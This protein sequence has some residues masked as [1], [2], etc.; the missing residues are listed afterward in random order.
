MA[1]ELADRRDRLFGREGDLAALMKRARYKGLTAVVARPQKGKSW[2]LTE[3]AR[4]LGAEPQPPYL[5]G[6]AESFGE[7]PDLLLRTVVDL[8]ARWL[9]DAGSLEKARKLWE[10]E[11]ANLLPGVAMAV[12]KIFKELADAVTKPAAVVVEE[13]FNGLIAA[14]ERPRTGGFKLPTLR[15]EQ[16]RDLVKSV[17]DI[18][19][20]P[21]ALF[22]DQWEK[23]PDAALE[24]KTLDSSL[25]HLDYWPRCHIFLALRPDRLAHGEV[26][27]LAD[28]MPGAAE[29]YPLH[30]MELSL[31]EGRRLTAFVRGTVSAAVDQSDEALLGMVDGYPGVIY[32]W[33]RDYQRAHMRTRDDLQ[34]VAADAQEYRFSDLKVLL[35]K[36]D[37][38]HRRLA[39]RLALLPVSAAPVWASI[40]GEVL[41]GL[42]AGLM[43]DLRLANLLESADPPSFGH[44]QRWEAAR[45]WVV[46]NL[47][48]NARSEAESLISSIAAPVRELSLAVLPNV[49]ILFGLLPTARQLKLDDLS[50]ALCQSAASLLLTAG[51]ADGA[52]IRRARQTSKLRTGTP[53]LAMGLL[54][55]LIDAKAEGHLTRR[56]AL[57]EELRALAGAQPEDTAIREPLAR[58]VLSALSP[59]KTEDDRKRRDALLEELRALA[60]AHPKDAAV[61]EWL[62]KG[63]FS[64]LNCAKAEDDLT[65]RDA[66]LEEL[67]ALTRAHPED[68]AIREWRAQSLLN[69]LNHAKAED[70]SARR[71]ALLE[72]L[73][74]LAAAHP[75]EGAVRRQLAMG[76]FNALNH[77]NAEDDLV[78]R[79]DLL[80]ELRALGLAHP[81]DAAVREWLAKGLYNIL[82]FA[83]AEDHR[84]LC[85]A[86]LEELW[87][88]AAAHPKDA[89]VRGRLAMGLFNVLDFANAEDD[90]ARCDTLLRECGGWPR[91]TLRTRLCANSWPRAC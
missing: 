66:L 76:L 30:D 74:A 41:G 33:T 18:S 85:D 75:E 69:T 81:E 86:L 14:D 49:A 17:A 83:K 57:L 10:N 26:Q 7:T 27:K 44:A 65:R 21:I 91:R 62:A 80:E 35:P 61:R 71:D 82:N 87:T 59:A 58:G 56:D 22:L 32:Q 67:R 55:T 6:F 78:R 84:E 3:L 77:A 36:L 23:S 64:T 45:G 39:I 12:A 8:Y 38:D 42:G 47:P 16:A 48:N 60:A 24:S 54:N 37:G 88:L 79:A 29:I 20:R 1:R 72:E 63:V 73:R 90:P 40:K 43:D 5:V 50:L 2:L 25:R 9:S 46:E 51:E 53:L 28:S 4:R 68:P 31:D 89:I 13:A 70:N 34:Q 11:K 52:L 15:Y 19:G